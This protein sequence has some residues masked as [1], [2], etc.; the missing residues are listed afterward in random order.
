MLQ[1]I[2]LL[3]VYTQPDRP[4]GRGRQL[5]ASPIKE[6][7]LA[8][9]LPVLQPQSLRD[10]DVQAELAAFQPDVM[11][12]V[13]YGLILPASVLTIPRL[14]CINVHASLLPRWRGAAPIQRALLHGDSETGVSI[15]Q[16]EAGLDTGPVFARASCPIPRGM[17]G[18]E[19]HD[20]L[21]VLGA[22]AL[23]KQ[24]PAIATGDVVAQPQDELQ[25]N[26]AE[27]LSKAEAE[28]DWTASA[29][30]LERKVLAFNPWPVAQ[31]RAGSN[32]LRIWRAQAYDTKSH[33][34]S[35]HI[36]PG[37][38]LLENN[39]G[40]Y[41]ATGAGELCLTEIQLPGKRA[42]KAIDFLNARRSLAG[43]ILG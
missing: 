28:L 14:G 17:T 8:A 18:G 2:R 43:V 22:E 33:T 20:R 13:A 10:S 25:A 1:G 37:Q 16:M 4:A 30:E 21:A 15:M 32:T 3:A 23:V 7:A 27:K 41:V 38:V 36:Q 19:L 9:N 26:Y 39:D 24:L 42:I 11:I 29:L 6:R 40:I 35:D 5:R 34:Q 12:V 31:T